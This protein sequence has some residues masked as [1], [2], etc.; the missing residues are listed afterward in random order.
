MQRGAEIDIIL[1][2][3]KNIIQIKPDSEFINSLY[4]QYC[5]RG[6][7]SKKQLEGL[8]S[9]ASKLPG[10]HPGKLATL[11]AII[12]KRPNRFKSE[13]PTPAVEIEAED[14]SAYLISEV[15]HKFPEHKRVLFF[16]LKLEKKEKLTAFEKSEL[17]KFHALS[18]RK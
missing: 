4:H 2:L 11:Q 1:D 6:N 7:L 5:E 10:I 16:K 14:N 3:L 17:E 9:K 15:L 13:I 18:I 8:Y 12:M